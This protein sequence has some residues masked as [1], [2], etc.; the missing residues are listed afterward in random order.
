M[1]VATRYC[2]SCGKAVAA[3]AR[4][5]PS[6]GATLSIQQ[7]PPPGYTPAPG[8]P[9]Y[10]APYQPTP[11]KSNTTLIIVVVVIAVVVVA[12]IVGVLAL[13]ALFTAVNTRHSQTLVNQTVTVQPGQYN[14]YEFAVPS[15]ATSVIV[16]GTFTASGGSGNDIQVLIFD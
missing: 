11:K 14:Y 4:F 1:A 3:E 13:G 9:T 12:A 15:G 2:P 16:N 5:C 6:C 10:Q 7:P 8:Y